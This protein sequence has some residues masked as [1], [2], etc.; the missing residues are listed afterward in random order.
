[1][2]EY[3]VKSEED[4]VQHQVRNWIENTKG[5]HFKENCK[6]LYDEKNLERL[7]RY[8]NSNEEYLL[9]RMDLN[10]E[11]LKKYHTLYYTILTAFTTGFI[12]FLS[13]Q[14]LLKGLTGEIT[15]IINEL[16]IIKI[17][18]LA[19]MVISL[20]SGFSV[21][22]SLKVRRF[23]LKRSG[24][25]NVL[26]DTEIEIYYISKIFEYRKKQKDKKMADKTL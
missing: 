24:L 11:V 13:S 15:S 22:F 18:F 20:G 10:E 5:D 9:K 16:N 26:H 3:N 14:L 1:M 4:W 17:F 23:L 19:L 8:H 7:K 21:I 25:L 12:L 6:P 2:K